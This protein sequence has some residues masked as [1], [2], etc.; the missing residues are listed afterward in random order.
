MT[1]HAGA[2]DVALTPLA[3]RARWAVAVVRTARPRQW[4][5]NLLV[6]AAPLAGASL[7][8]RDG[9]AYALV[10]AAPPSTRSRKP[11]ATK[12]S[13]ITATCLSFHE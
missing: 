10:A 11:D 7:G 12:S 2:T 5:K 3:R 9:L 8:R 13:S 6:F 4:P 1:T